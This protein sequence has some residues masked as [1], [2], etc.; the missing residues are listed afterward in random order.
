MSFSYSDLTMPNIRMRCRSALQDL[1]SGVASLRFTQKIFSVMSDNRPT[2]YGRGFK[3]V[4]VM[5]WRCIVYEVR[6]RIYAPEEL[7]L[8]R[9]VFEQALTSLPVAT[10]T[11]E[12]RS[13]LARNLLACAATGERDPTEL[14]IA[15]LIDLKAA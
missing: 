3:I 15:A 1:R 4:F 6:D 14:R 7:M 13:R 8:F 12:N 2:E 9:R 10:R 11:D 5:R